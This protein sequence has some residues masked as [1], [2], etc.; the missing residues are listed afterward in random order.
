MV[1]VGRKQAAMVTALLLAAPGAARAAVF[2][3][4]HVDLGE[5]DVRA[6]LIADG[7]LRTEP[8][9]SRSLL[10]AR[11]TLTSN[12]AEAKVS[13]D[14]TRLAFDCAGKRSKVLSEA[15]YAGVDPAAK[16]IDKTHAGE[17]VWRA[18][19]AGGDARDL[20]VFACSGPRAV[21]TRMLAFQQQD[22]WSAIGQATDTLSRM[23][24]R[25]LRGG[26]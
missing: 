14:Q 26:L 12:G 8:D 19:E 1:T 5:Q 11:I 22:L 4:T 2:H 10:V 18:V 15:L 21:K 7:E 9:A 13:V 17:P 20:Y 25:A 23:L 24:S 6:D 16:P 3:M